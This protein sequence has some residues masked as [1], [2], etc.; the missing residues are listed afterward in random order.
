LS[1]AALQREVGKLRQRLDAV[2][3]TDFFASP[4]AGEAQSA[5]ERLEALVSESPRPPA[6][7]RLD[8]ASFKGRVWLT[9]PRP[10]IDRMASAWLIQRFIAPDAA[11]AFG[12]LPAKKGQIP[13]DMPDVEFGHY[14]TDCTYETL[15]RRF[16]ITDAAALRVGHIVHDLDLKESRYGLPDTATIGRLVQGLRDAGTS[17]HDILENGIRMIE[18]LY[19]S[20]VHDAREAA[21]PRRKRVVTKKKRRATASDKFQKL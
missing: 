8:R 19:R 2:K 10:G 18:A 16:G 9:R 17:D 12:S 13:F 4:R 15:V 11:F 7:K 5:V 20:F 21:T 3:T 1:R 6:T 14:G